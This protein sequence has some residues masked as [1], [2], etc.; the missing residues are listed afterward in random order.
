MNWSGLCFF[1]RGRLRSTPLFRTTVSRT[2]VIVPFALPYSTRNEMRFLRYL[3]L[4]I[5]ALAVLAPAAHA[6]EMPN[7]F[8]LDAALWLAVQ[9]HLYRGWGPLV[10]APTEIMGLLIN[11][12][13]ACAR[14][15]R[16]EHRRASALAACAYAGMLGVFWI[17]N[18]P[19]N[20]AV[21]T[22]TPATLP[23]DWPSYRL[24]WETG[25]ASAAVLSVVAL[26]AVLYGY[27]S[28][29]GH[30]FGERR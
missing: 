22:W 12:A 18:A 15:A 19:V 2:I 9:Q 6:L 1:N 11:T 14:S 30:V 10:G 27:V 7:T 23:L 20:A 26:V 8:A 16:R 21:A 25:H 13:L 17:F 29:R 4:L 24:R 5:A 3:S 28:A